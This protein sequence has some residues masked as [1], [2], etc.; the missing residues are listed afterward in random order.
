[1]DLET[2]DPAAGRALL[3]SLRVVGSD[4]ELQALVAEFGPLALTISLLG[5]W[6]YEQPGHAATAA[7]GLPPGPDPLARVLAGVEALLGDGPAL[8]LL[9]VQGLFDRPA[10]SAQVA[11][12]LDIEAPHP[13]AIERLRELRL[14][15]PHSRHQPDVLEAHPLIREHYARWLREDAPERFRDGHRRVYEHLCATTEHRPDGFAGLQPLY[16]AVAHGCL[17]GLQQQALDDVYFARILRGTGNDAFYSWKKLGAIGADLAAVAAFFDRRWDRPS[18]A[19]SAPDRAWLLNEAAFR[20]RALGRLGDALGPMRAG[21]E[22]AVEQEYWKNAAIRAGNLSELELS[23]GKVPDAVSDAGR[24]VDFAERSGDEFWRM[25]MRTTHAD[26]LQQAGEPERAEALFVE[27]EALQAQQQPQYPRLYSLQ[28]FRYCDLLLSVAE[29]GA[30]RWMGL[31]DAPSTETSALQQ[32]CAQAI[33][34]ATKTLEWAER[35]NIDLLS[36]ALDHLTLARATLY[37][38]VLSQQPGHPPTPPDTVTTHL[39]AAVDGLRQAGSMDHLPS[40]LLTRA[41]QRQLSGDRAGAIAD[42]D[43]ATELAESG[44]MP[45]Y[46]VDILLTRARLFGLPP[47]TTP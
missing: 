27:T 29:V 26:A 43:E 10:P 19:L 36:A 20:L 38:A 46:Q 44:P 45:L 31:A 5:A 21:L 35:N 39:S 40:G 6:L 33:E 30:W 1:L 3:R 11:A 12:T 2:L 34:R 28:G 15:A 25:V 23:L 22:M 7:A 17:A 8:E 14:L 4:H 18:P 16:Q 42:L 32:T 37:Q 9:R 47:T 41:W 24:A 13:A